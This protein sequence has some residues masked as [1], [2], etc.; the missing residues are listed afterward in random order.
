MLRTPVSFHCEF[1]KLILPKIE[2][3]I[4][5]QDNKLVNW[6]KNQIILKDLQFLLNHYETLSKSLTI[7]YQLEIGLKYN[8]WKNTSTLQKD[9]PLYLK[10]ISSL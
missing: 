6:P 5:F 10:L 2:N 3:T 4:P 7:E 8:Q 1:P 9:S